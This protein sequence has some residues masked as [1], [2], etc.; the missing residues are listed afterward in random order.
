MGERKRQYDKYPVLNSTILEYGRVAC[1]ENARRLIR[2]AK[3]LGSVLSYRTGYLLLLLACEEL[4]KAVHLA[5]YPERTIRNDWSKWWREF[6]SHAMKQRS[7]W[8]PLIFPKNRLGFESAIMKAGEKMAKLREEMTYVDFDLEGWRFTSPPGDIALQDLFEQEMS[9]VN[10][11]LEKLGEPRKDT[12]KEMEEETESF[13][14]EAISTL[15]DLIQQEIVR[16]S[17]EVTGWTG[18]E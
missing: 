15:G 16:R 7:S 13:S 4:G 10:R 1:V 12:I 14:E 17:G 9:Y 3:E 8:L 18:E 11:V 6:F 5:L 2:D